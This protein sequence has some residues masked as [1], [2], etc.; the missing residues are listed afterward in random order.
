[1]GLS[2][3]SIADEMR[4][5][6]RR[7]LPIRLLCLSQQLRQ[8]GDVRRDLRFSFRLPTGRGRYWFAEKLVGRSQIV[9][10]CCC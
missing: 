7:R 3:T 2:R 5:E 1:M 10:H 4:E 8:L 9:F 6:H